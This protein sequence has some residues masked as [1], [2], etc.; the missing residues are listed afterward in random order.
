[1]L[2]QF[3]FSATPNV[4]LHAYTWKFLALNWWYLLCPFI[5]LMVICYYYSHC[6]Y[7]NSITSNK[8]TTHLVVLF[9]WVTI[10]KVTELDF[11]WHNFMQK[12]VAS[13]WVH[14]WHMSGGWPI[15]NSVYSFWSIVYLCFLFS[16]FFCSS[17]FE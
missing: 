17:L 4:Q 2:I 1:M 16:Y 9:V 15:S 7:Y 14:M 8:T 10:F 13:W 11:W 6:C 12:S 3:L 5:A